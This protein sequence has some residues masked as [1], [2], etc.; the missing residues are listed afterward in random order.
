M[1]Q[2]YLVM[3]VYDLPARR[4]EEDSQDKK[5]PK[6]NFSPFPSTVPL[7]E[8]YERKRLN[9][10]GKPPGMQDDEAIRGAKAWY[11][12]SKYNHPDNVHLV[13]NTEQLKNLSRFHK[14]THMLKTRGNNMPNSC[15]GN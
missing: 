9:L 1:T 4:W 11:R 6:S 5:R 10:R 12:E 8:Q 2:A 7:S 15:T 13:A 14:S 3:S